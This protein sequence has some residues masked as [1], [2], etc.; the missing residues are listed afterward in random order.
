MPGIEK[1]PAIQWKIMNIRKLEKQK[2]YKL[3]TKLQEALQA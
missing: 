1:L 2:H 3:M